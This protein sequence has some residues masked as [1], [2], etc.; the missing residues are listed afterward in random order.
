M[1]RNAGGGVQVRCD[2]CMCRKAGGG[3]LDDVCVG[4]QVVVFWMM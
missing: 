2:L 3:V 1:C 4:M